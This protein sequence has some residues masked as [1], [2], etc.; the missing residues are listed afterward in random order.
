M[1]G[2]AWYASTVLDTSSGATRRYYELLRRK[3]GIERLAMAAALT[4]AVRELAEAGIR[5]EHPDLTP[6][7]LQARLTERLYGS[8]VAHRLFG[9]DPAA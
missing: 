4:R 5:F 9:S 1:C 2:T 7:Q 3:S 8:A 6:R